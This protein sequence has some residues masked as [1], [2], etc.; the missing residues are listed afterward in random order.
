MA[1]VGIQR[2][3]D[4]TPITNNPNVPA[5]IANSVHVGS[6]VAQVAGKKVS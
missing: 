4:I 6:Y 3:N 2:K 1:I 5:N